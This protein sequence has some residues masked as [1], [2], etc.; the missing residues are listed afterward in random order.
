ALA[1]GRVAPLLTARGLS[2]GLV[3]S[4]IAAALNTLTLATRGADGF[5]NDF[6]DYWGAAGLIARGG[7][8][9]DNAALFALVTGS[10]LPFQVGTGYSYPAF[11]AV[12][13]MPLAAL[14]PVTAAWIF[15]AIGLL[16]FALAIAILLSPLRQ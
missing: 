9:Y 16:A 5:F 14:P 6:Y 10:G 4:S 13:M 12:L 8:P 1:L 3:A 11:F 7:N 2:A 15:T